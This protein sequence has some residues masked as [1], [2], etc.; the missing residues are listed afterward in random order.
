MLWPAEGWCPA[1]SCPPGNVGQGQQLDLQPQMETLLG[2]LR[3]SIPE[4]AI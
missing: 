1:G 2:G 3:P 4:N